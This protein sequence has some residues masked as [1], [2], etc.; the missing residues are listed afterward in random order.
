MNAPLTGQAFTIDVSEVHTFIVNFIKQNYEAESI[1]KIFEDE[2]NRRKDW[3]ILKNHY[4]GQ[5]IYTN[6]ISK[7]NADLKNLFYGGEKKPH[8]WSIKFECR[9]NLAFQTYVKREGRV[10]HSDEMKLRK[11]LENV[12]C[13]WLNQIKATILVRLT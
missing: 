10:V 2:R 5:D 13:E 4:K 6:N 1:I 12:K 11:L 8:I 3:T 9:L 7:A